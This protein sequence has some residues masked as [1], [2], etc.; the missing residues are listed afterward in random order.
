[1]ANLETINWEHTKMVL[2][3]KLEPRNFK[4]EQKLFNDG[5]YYKILEISKSKKVTRLK[6]INGYH[7]KLKSLSTPVTR[8][9][10]LDSDPDYLVIE[11]GV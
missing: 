5:F 3:V 2:Q 1:M 9:V 10:A 8:W 4:S 11:T 6:N 7:L